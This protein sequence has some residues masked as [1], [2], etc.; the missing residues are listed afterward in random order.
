MISKSLL[1][2]AVTLFGLAAT[3]AAAPTASAATTH[4]LSID[5]SKTTASKFGISTFI[6]NGINFAT[7]G[8]MYAELI[9]DRAF[10]EDFSPHWVS[11]GGAKANQTTKNPLSKSLPN[12]VI[13][14]PGNSSKTSGLL[15][16]G[17]Y[18][19]PVR[20]QTYAVSFYA[21]SANGANAQVTAKA[22][23]YDTANQKEWA[24]VE[25]P[26]TLTGQWQ[27]YKVRAAA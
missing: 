6:E 5:T 11:T 21:R 20:P 16:K 17:Y 22:G 1:L 7:D 10:Q 13:V 12:S 24:S 2:L 23:L 18:G 8:G 9:R 25:V 14:T 4:S 19:I 15:N 27:Q 26:L 3:T